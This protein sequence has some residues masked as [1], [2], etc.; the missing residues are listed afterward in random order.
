V[1]YIGDT[2]YFYLNRPGH[3]S[4][5][6]HEKCLTGQNP[7]MSGNLTLSEIGLFHLKMPVRPL[8]TQTGWLNNHSL[9]IGHMSKIAILEALA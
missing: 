4:A 6:L 3:H 5:D 9:P 7:S 1:F 2:Q 8:S